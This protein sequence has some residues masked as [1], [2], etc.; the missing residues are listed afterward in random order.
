[1]AHNNH[2]Q[3]G[4]VIS[5]TSGQSFSPP[6]PEHHDTMTL[7]TAFAENPQGVRFETQHQEEEVVVFL[8]QHFVV[9]LPWILA[10]MLLVVAPFGI[11]PFI[12][13]Y[14]PLPFAIPAQYSLVALLFWYLATTGYALA[15]FIR[16]YYNIYIVTTERIIDI[17]FIQ[18]LY[19]KFSEARLENIEDITYTSPGFFA[20]VFHYGNVYIQTAAETK[21]FE[22]LSVP[23]PANVTQTISSMIKKST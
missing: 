15:N 9:N 21:Q 7:F 20:T 3:H 23:N 13:M 8:R 2:S 11:V 16:W 19:K 1:M 5:T 22:F 4:H 18:L 17:D 6:H 10:T 12:L 14:V